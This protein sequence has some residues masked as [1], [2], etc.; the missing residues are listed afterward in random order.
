MM[1]EKKNP[2]IPL[3][4]RMRPKNL[5]DFVGQEEII[6]KDSF[7][8]KAIKDDKVPSLVFWGPPGSG[9]T[10]LANIIAHETKAEFIK[11]SAVAS[12]LQELRKIIVLAKE[13]LQ[14]GRKT[15]FFLDEIHR[16][17]KAQQDAL[18]P[19]IEDGTIVL[20][21]ATTENPSFSLNNALISRTRVVVLKELTELDVEKIIWQAVR[22]GDN[23]VGKRLKKVD[24]G[25]V[26]FL[27]K[28][29]NGD[30]RMALNTL[31][32]AVSRND[33]L[34]EKIIK[35]VL[36]KMHLRYDKNGEEHYN[37]ISALHKSMRGDDVQ[38]AIYWTVRMIE[39]GEDPR[40]IA[41]RMIRFA[42]EDIGLAD[43][44]ALV[45]ANSVY[46]TCQKIGL[47]ECN[48][49][50]VQCAAYL[51]KTK[52]S[53]AVYQAYKRAA[54]DVIDLG[55]LPVPMQIRN[56]PTKLM[57]NLGYGKDYKYSPLEDSSD[58]QYL[59][60]ELKGKKYLE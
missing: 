30:A 25:V 17:N 60:Q 45:L 26:K 57:K 21:G 36:Q 42:S 33:I 38:A 19:W 37:I 20:I 47:P 54:A 12:G 18:L 56:A 22:D 49:V 31:E 6:G 9:K 23:G 41:R 40:Y 16:W 59:P 5:D 24:D 32:L 11:M 29:S 14:L 10:T 13:N 48:T 28:M 52:K 50:L 3:A 46:D 35:Q 8:S 39:G 4:E 43:N 7:L 27:A 51:A 15:I 1:F 34:T 44:F 55:N 2:N 58:Q 53:I